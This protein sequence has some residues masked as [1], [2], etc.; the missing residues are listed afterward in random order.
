MVKKCNGAK[1]FLD[2]YASGS[3]QILAIDIMALAVRQALH[4]IFDDYNA[5]TARLKMVRFIKDKEGGGAFS[6]ALEVHETE[7][8]IHLEAN[9]E[10]KSRIIDQISALQTQE[11]ATVEEGLRACAEICNLQRQ[12]VEVIT[13]ESSIRNHYGTEK[14]QLYQSFQ[15]TQKDC[16]TQRDKED[17]NL[18]KDCIEA[19][20]RRPRHVFH[21]V[22]AD[23]L[24]ATSYG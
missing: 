2:H 6:A 9:S 3:L 8:R 11:M 14:I 19:L 15:K 10:H 16:Q 20:V 5:A 22:H 24:V 23:A 21:D 17:Y 12:L 7:R 18:A 4:K 1:I 13:A